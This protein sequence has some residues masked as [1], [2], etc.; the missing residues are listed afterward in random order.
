PNQLGNIPHERVLQDSAKRQGDA[1]RGE[2]LF[3][4]QSCAA[5]HTVVKGQSPIG[6][7][8]G[9]VGKRYKRIQLAESLLKPSAVLAQGFET[10]LFVMQNG[11]SHTGFVIREAAEEVEI[12]TARGRSFVLLKTEIEQRAKGK[13]SVMPDG[14]INNLTLEEFASLLDYLESLRTK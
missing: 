8:L 9:D 10:N 13:Q 7:H 5:C 2:Q 3:K 14:L 12:R 6:P 4:R 1:T 11:K